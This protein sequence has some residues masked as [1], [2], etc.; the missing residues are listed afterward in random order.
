MG[1]TP[2]EKFL[3]LSTARLEKSQH[4]IKQLT[5]LGSKNYEF[6]EGEA[7]EIY[8]ALRTSVDDV[9]QALGVLE[10]PEVTTLPEEQFEAFS[11]ACDELPE[12]EEIVLTKEENRRLI[13]LGDH[14][15][16]AINALED[17]EPDKAYELLIN[18]MRS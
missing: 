9:A 15:G 14:L 10:I 17:K 7:L 13:T 4:A 6:S 11:K 8:H 18:L 1:E 16:A 5:H 2:N 3:R 12:E